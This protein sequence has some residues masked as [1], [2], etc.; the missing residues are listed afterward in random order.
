MCHHAHVHIALSADDR[1]DVKRLAGIMM[2]V[3]ASIVLAVIAAVSLAGGQGQGEI[4]ASQ[5]TSATAR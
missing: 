3:Y 5:P 2:P 1:K 4:F